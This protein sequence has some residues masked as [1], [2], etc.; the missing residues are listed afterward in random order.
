[1]TSYH[2]P[3]VA[4]EDAGLGA[5]DEEAL[6]NAGLVSGFGAAALRR[7]SSPNCGEDGIHTAVTA[8]TVPAHVTPLARERSNGSNGQRRSASGVGGCV[9]AEQSSGAG[10]QLHWNP[11][12]DPNAMSCSP[13][14]GLMADR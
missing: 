11:L 13:I 12:Y 9:D 10:G 1:V 8:A 2:N 14:P 6:L 4:L 7:S 5:A 3:M